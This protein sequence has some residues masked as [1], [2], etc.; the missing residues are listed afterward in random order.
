MENLI[1]IFLGCCGI[2]HFNVSTKTLRTSLCWLLL[3]RSPLFLKRQKVELGLKKRGSWQTMTFKQ[4]FISAAQ[5]WSICCPIFFSKNLKWEGTAY[6][7]FLVRKADENWIN[8]ECEHN[9]DHKCTI[10]SSIIFILYQ[11]AF[12]LSPTS[13][14]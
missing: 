14:G 5:F 10:T 3:W 9:S 13:A 7:F 12:T 1:F 2:S 8:Y 6:R 11:I 4:K